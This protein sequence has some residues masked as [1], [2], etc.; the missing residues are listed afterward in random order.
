MFMCIYIYIYIYIRT[1]VSGRRRGRPA[2]RDARAAR[3]ADARRLPLRRGGR[4][5]LLRSVF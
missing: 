2:A 4:P 5:P 1:H 3:D